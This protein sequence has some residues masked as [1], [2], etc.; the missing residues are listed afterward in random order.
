M[1]GCLAV[2]GL[3]PALPAPGSDLLLLLAAAALVAALVLRV[4]AQRS[5]AVRCGL[6][7]FRRGCAILARPRTYL[8]RVIPWQGASRALRFLSLGC[9]LAAFGLPVTVWAVLLVAATQGG[10]RALPLG[11][12]SAGLGGALLAG[13]FSAVT[14]EPAE[15]A[16][17]VAFTLGTSLALTAV[18]LALTTVV[19]ARSVPLRELP[20]LLATVPAFATRGTRTPAA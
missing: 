14:G 19:V 16:T 18:G 8:V 10:G 3:A 6:V 20:T 9:L 4:V 13:A 11:P 17:L 12:G 15:V 5:R 7:R 2:H 1:L